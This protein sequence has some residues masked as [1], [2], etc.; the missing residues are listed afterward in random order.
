MGSQRSLMDAMPFIQ[1]HDAKILQA[2][3]AQ[4]LNLG[5]GGTGTQALGT[6]LAK[7][8]ETSEDAN[9]RWIEETINQRLVRRWALWS[10][11][12][13]LR[14]PVVRHK[15]IKSNDLAQ[16]SSAL[17]GLMAGGVVHP[18]LD[19]DEYVRDL[20]ELPREQLEVLER[21]QKAEPVGAEVREREGPRV[22]A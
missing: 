5:Q 9:A 18:T 17:G 22:E 10:Y 16:W 2:G 6:V 14:P 8:F 12:P 11:G 20:F 4:F 1:H 19:D 3:L 7:L 21:E 15:P 13:K